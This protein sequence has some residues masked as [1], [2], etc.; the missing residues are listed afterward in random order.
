MT[1]KEELGQFK[2]W[3]IVSFGLLCCA[4][5]IVMDSIGKHDGDITQ[6]HMLLF[7]F[8]CSL[9]MFI[10]NRNTIN[11][12]PIFGLLEEENKDV[13]EETKDK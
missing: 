13:S 7:V 6:G 2:I 10:Y 11:D 5:C 4:F 9:A 1:I 3:V 8:C 12:K